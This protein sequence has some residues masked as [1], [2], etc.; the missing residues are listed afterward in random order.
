MGIDHCSSLITPTVIRCAQ[1]LTAAQHLGVPER[2]PPS[3]YPTL[4]NQT[5]GRIAKTC[6]YPCAVAGQTTSTP[7]TRTGVPS[8]AR[9][10]PHRHHRVPTSPSR[11][12]SDE[13]YLRRGPG[14]GARRSAVALRAAGRWVRV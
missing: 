5:E 4:S 3:A 7:A 2:T 13:K 11:A 14:S 1:I 6:G 12:S 8:G 10:K 9:A